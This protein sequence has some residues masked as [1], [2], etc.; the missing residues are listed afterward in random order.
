M[1]CS[2]KTSSESAWRPSKESLSLAIEFRTGTGMAE[3]HRKRGLD[4]EE[5][6]QSP[7]GGRART[8]Q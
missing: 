6:N 1:P 2:H 3:G 8:T 5:R 7:L 4:G